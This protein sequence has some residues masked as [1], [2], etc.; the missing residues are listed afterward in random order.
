MTLSDQQAAKID[1]SLRDR[2]E[3]AERED[4]LRTVVVLNSANERRSEPFSP[5][6]A[7]FPTRQAY[8]QALINNKKN[9][10][11]HEF[12]DIKER[13]RAHSLILKGGNLTNLL[14]VEGHA[15]DIVTVL[16]WPEIKSM[17]LDQPLTR[18]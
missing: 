13:L 2:L 16:A 5:H 1:S 11:E 10:V 15:E 8:R 14:I 12:G 18:D 4:L 9:A 17:S 3:T 6:P 7:N